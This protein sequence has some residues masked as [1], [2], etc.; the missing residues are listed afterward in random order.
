MSTLIAPEYL[1]DC[2][3][4]NQAIMRLQ[5]IYALEGGKPRKHESLLRLLDKRSDEILPRDFI[6]VALAEG[7]MPRLDTMVLDQLK[8]QFKLDEAPPPGRIAVNVSR[9]SLNNE[10]YCNHL[11]GPCRGLLPH[12]VLEVG[13]A[14]MM[15][16]SL[17]YHILKSFKPDGA[18]IAVDYPGGGPRMAELTAKLGFDYIKVNVGR[19]VGSNNQLERLR[20]TCAVAE[21]AGLSVIFEGIETKQDMEIVHTMPASLAQGFL[22][23][24]PQFAFTDKPLAAE[25]ARKGHPP[26][27]LRGAVPAAIAPVTDVFTP[28]RR[29]E[30]IP[31]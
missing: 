24:M 13:A 31:Q 22:L 23:G 4:A 10:H 6:P 15:S 12:L 14:D 16:D 18:H 29:E 7:L 25:F 19:A 2:L 26:A 20:E 9:R 17:T 8:S 21:Q 11:L 28:T 3:D 27:I 1:L 30:M 5:P